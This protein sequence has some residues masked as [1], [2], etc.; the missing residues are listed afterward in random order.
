M[1]PV[2]AVSLSPHLLPPAAGARCGLHGGPVPLPPHGPARSGTGAVLPLLFRAGYRQPSRR[3]GCRRCILGSRVLWRGVEACQK[4]ILPPGAQ[5]APSGMVG[6]TGVQLPLVRGWGSEGQ[7]RSEAA[8]T[9]AQTEKGKEKLEPE[10]VTH[11]GHGQQSWRRVT[12]VGAGR[13]VW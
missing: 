4:G 6:V 2:Q 10:E 5:L 8:V 12:R 9:L 7:A 1:S 11:H 3:A 13:P